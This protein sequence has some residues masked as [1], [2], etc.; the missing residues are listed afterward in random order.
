MSSNIRVKKKCEYCESVFVAKTTRTRYCTPIC[1][2]KDYKK[3]A[4]EKKI[5]AVSNPE[6]IKKTSVIDINQKD[7][8]TVKETAKI[9]NM[10]IRTVYR[11]LE[12]GE[13]N[14]YNFAE[15]LLTIRR[16]DLESYFDLNLINTKVD[17]EK[18][19]KMITLENSYSMEEASKKYDISLSALYNLIKR[20]EIPSKQH[21]K[22]VLV[23]KIDIDKIF[24]DN[25]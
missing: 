18:I 9:L 14:S 10:S 20:L 17:K 13:I 22:Y 7:F 5:G 19:T 3:K 12:R 16:K 6:I 24:T 15:R 2:K 4:R 11:L 23:K 1:N 25:D 8:L 21:G